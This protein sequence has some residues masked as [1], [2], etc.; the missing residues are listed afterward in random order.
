MDLQSLN[1]VFQSYVCSEGL[2]NHFLYLI[3]N[4]HKCRIGGKKE[5]VNSSSN[6]YLDE[7]Y[8]RFSVCFVFGWGFFDSRRTLIIY[9]CRTRKKSLRKAF[10]R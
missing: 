8:E 9:Y 6:F 2:G 1:A 4:T 7:T 3:I 10:L 5:G